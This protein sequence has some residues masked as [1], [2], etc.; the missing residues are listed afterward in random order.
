MGDRIMA[1]DSFTIYNLP[2]AVNHYTTETEWMGDCIMAD[3]S[4]TV[5][6]LPMAVNVYVAFPLQTGLGQ[7]CTLLHFLLPGLCL[8][9]CDILRNKSAFLG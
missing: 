6:S 9:F 7:S 8:L 2:M 3:D 5:Y 1:D 4:F